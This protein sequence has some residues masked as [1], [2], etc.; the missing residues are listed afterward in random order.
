[1]ANSP[2]G[3]MPPASYWLIFLVYSSTVKVETIYSSETVVF[4]EVHDVTIQKI[5]R[6]IVAAEGTFQQELFLFTGRT[7]FEATKK[8]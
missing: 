5:I 3:C 4:S 8:I 6:F 2:T 1:M 7:H